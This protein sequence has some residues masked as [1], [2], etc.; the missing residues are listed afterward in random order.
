MEIKFDNLQSKSFIQTINLLSEFSEKIQIHAKPNSFYIF[1]L[2]NSMLA[3]IA[4]DIRIYEYQCESPLYI[5][6]DTKL[7]L[8]KL[9]KY[10]ANKS[11]SISIEATKMC[12]SGTRK[13]KQ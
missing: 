11:I 5:E 7:L 1:S 4:F 2:K 6:Y 13:K 8:N 10:D 9:K 12:V 3:K